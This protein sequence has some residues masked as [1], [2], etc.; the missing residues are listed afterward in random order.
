LTASRAAA[1]G[2]HALV[3]INGEGTAYLSINK[4]DG[5]RT[6]PPTF[7]SISSDAKIKDSEGFPQSQVIM[8]G[9]D[10]DGRGDYLGLDEQVL[11][12]S[13]SLLT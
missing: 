7:K 8:G 12:S 13:D 3:C 1:D 10:G 6:R 11:F 2:L 4:G 5:S 9:I